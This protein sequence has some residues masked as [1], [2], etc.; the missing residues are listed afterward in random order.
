MGADPLPL[1]DQQFVSNL[2]QTLMEG[3]APRGV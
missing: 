1:S 2:V 3:A